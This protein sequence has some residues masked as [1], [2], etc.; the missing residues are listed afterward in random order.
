MTNPI[1][2]FWKL[3]KL[4]YTPSKIKTIIP[5]KGSIEY[6][7]GGKDPVLA[8]EQMTERHSEEAEDCTDELRALTDSY[9]D[10]SED[11]CRRVRFLEKRLEEIREQYTGNLPYDPK[12]FAGT[13]YAD[14]AKRIH[15]NH[16]SIMRTLEMDIRS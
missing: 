10:L 3:L 1:R 7:L 6:I 9:D 8:Y 4:L 14:A 12:L 11:G 5:A 13:A 2:F 15:E 16:L